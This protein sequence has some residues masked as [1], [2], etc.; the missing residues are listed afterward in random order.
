MKRSQINRCIQEFLDFAGRQQFC[1][2]AWARRTPQEWS[3]TGRE[4]DEIRRCGLGWDVTDFGSGDFAKVGLTLFTLRN[5]QPGT[6][7]PE[8]KDYCEKVMMVRE[9]QLT[10]YHFHF[11]KM[12]DIINRGGGRLVIKLYQA[13]P[14]EELDQSA[15]VSVQVDGIRRT[16]PAGGELLL[17]PGESVSLVPRLYHC[18][19]GLTGGG[20]VLVGEVSRVNDDT[21]DNRFLQPLPRFPRIEED[22]PA[23]FVLCNE[24]PPPPAQ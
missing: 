13:T 17:A 16:F 23:R 19:L 5:G 20:P 7:G 14:E 15:R 10:P 21:R 9:D 8:A 22:E 4:A 11:S 6:A 1:F 3:R 12:E 2:P 24:Y 18:F